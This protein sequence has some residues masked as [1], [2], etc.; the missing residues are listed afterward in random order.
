MAG[1][2]SSIK[3][4]LIEQGNRPVSPP[5]RL[6]TITFPGHRTSSGNAAEPESPAG[7][8]KPRNRRSYERTRPQR[9][10]PP[11]SPSSATFSDVPPSAP[12]APDSLTDSSQFEDS[13]GLEDHWAREVFSDD[14]SAT[15]IPFVGER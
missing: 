14:L 7:E 10:P 1:L 9:L 11:A 15:R 13:Y 3:A 5:P 4:L 8:R 12:D 2:R 6:N